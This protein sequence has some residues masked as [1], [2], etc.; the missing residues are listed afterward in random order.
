MRPGGDT[1]IKKNHLFYLSI[2]LLLYVKII[3]IGTFVLFYF[4][5]FN[6]GLPI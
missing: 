2:P 1:N 6:L 5:W 4:S 3:T